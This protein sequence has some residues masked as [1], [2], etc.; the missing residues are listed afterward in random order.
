[1]GNTCS[2]SN[3][4][5]V[6]ISYLSPCFLKLSQD[7]LFFFGLSKETGN[8]Y[9]CVGDQYTREDI[10]NPALSST[11]KVDLLD[12]TQNGSVVIVS[13]SDAIKFEKL[14][15]GKILSYRLNSGPLDGMKAHITKKSER[16]FVPQGHAE[17]DK[18]AVLFSTE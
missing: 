14:E 9:I 16:K 15:S 7:R 3:K 2:Q 6:S 8:I 11:T 10:E 4:E 17:F 13:G 12:F 5:K 1:M 18:L